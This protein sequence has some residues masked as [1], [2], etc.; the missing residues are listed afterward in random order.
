M[1]LLIKYL[2]ED[3][4]AFI[5]VVYLKL[6]NDQRYGA[7]FDCLDNELNGHSF[8]F[9]GKIRRIILGNNSISFQLYSDFPS[10]NPYE[11]IND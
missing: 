4:T 2:D 6:Y 3:T 9:E 1:K 11:L 5:P 8:W 7:T 10:V